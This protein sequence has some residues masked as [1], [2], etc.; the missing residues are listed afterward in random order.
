MKYQDERE[1]HEALTLLNAR[2]AS[3]MEEYIAKIKESFIA[4]KVKLN[5]LKHNMDMSRISNPTDGDTERTKRYRREYRQVLEY[6]TVQ[7]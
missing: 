4:T 7:P 1:I 3:T 2:T 6:F 5:D